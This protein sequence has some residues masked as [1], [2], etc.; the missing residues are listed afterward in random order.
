MDRVKIYDILHHDFLCQVR[1]RFLEPNLL[2]SLFEKLGEKGIKI[3][4]FNSC[5]E[6]PGGLCLSFCVERSYMKATR[7]LLRQVK[8]PEEDI[9]I[10]PE[11][12]PV[13]IYGPHFVETPGIIDVMY[14]ALTSRGITVL[15]VST[16]ISTSFFVVRANSS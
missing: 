7:E 1:L 12:G 5:L 15:A 3:K 6:S 13:A 11:A 4:F 14:N 2:N 8:F 10:I 16:T 9:Q